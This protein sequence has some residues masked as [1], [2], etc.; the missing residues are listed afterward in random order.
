M[1]LSKQEGGLT[2][3]AEAWNAFLQ[4]LQSQVGLV[5]SQCLAD[6]NYEEGVVGWNTEAGRLQEL[7][8]YL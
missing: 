3:L 8:F 4:K 7:A 6:G 5:S 1:P 2:G